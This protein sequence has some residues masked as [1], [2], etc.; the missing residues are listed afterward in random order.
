MRDLAEESDSPTP[1][2]T[3]RV[4]GTWLAVPVDRMDRIV[5]ANR[6]VPVPLAAEDHIGL[7]ETGAAVVPVMRLAPPTAERHGEQLVALLRIRGETVGVTIDAAGRVYRSFHPRHDSAAPPAEI[8]ASA[9]VPAQAE[10]CP[11]WLVDPDRLWPHAS[12]GG[13][14]IAPS[15]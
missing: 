9:P 10:D 14:P 8:A 2:M 7:L 5:T 11:F 3:F 1:V 12:P 13:G 15:A 4:A 6:L